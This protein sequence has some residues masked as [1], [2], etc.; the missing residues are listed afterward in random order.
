MCYISNPCSDTKGTICA[1][2]L[3][4]LTNSSV[5]N[6]VRRNRWIMYYMVIPQQDMNF[7]GE[8]KRP[9]YTSLLQRSS[10]F[11]RC[12][13]FVLFCSLLSLSSSH[14][15]ICRL[16]LLYTSIL[17]LVYTIMEQSVDTF[18]YISG[19]PKKTLVATPVASRGVRSL[20][21][22]KITH[23]SAF[24]FRFLF[25]ILSDNPT[26]EIIT[27]HYKNTISSPYL[28]FLTVYLWIIIVRIV[29]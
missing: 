21:R 11:W 10:L 26:K 18:H 25:F 28:F 22:L 14:S 29:I 23:Q 1:I 7:S 17:S 15:V 13:L 19:L 24:G 12:Y 27:L 16:L 5:R 20:T 4:K 3:F 8:F 2:H 9:G 6:P